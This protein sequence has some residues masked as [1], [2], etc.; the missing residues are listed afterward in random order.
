MGSSNDHQQYYIRWNNHQSNLSLV[1]DQLFRTKA[2]A[3][4]TLNCEGQSIKCHKLVI[5]SCSSYFADLFMENN[6]G[7]PVHIPPGIRYSEFKVLLEFMYKGEVTIP[8]RQLASVLM[9][10]DKLKVRG[11]FNID[12]QMQACKFDTSSFPIVQMQTPCHPQ[13]SLVSANSPQLVSTPRSPCI[14]SLPGSAQTPRS[15]HTKSSLSSGITLPQS[16]NIESPPYSVPTPT[17]QPSSPS[18]YLQSPSPSAP[19]PLP[20]TQPLGKAGPLYQYQYQL[21]LAPISAPYNP[22]LLQ[23]TSAQPQHPVKLEPGYQPQ[24]PL[25][26]IP[27]PNPPAQAPIAAGAGPADS[28]SNTSIPQPYS[29]PQSYFLHTTATSALPISF[30]FY[31]A[32]QQSSIDHSISNFNVSSNW[33]TDGPVDRNLNISVSL[34]LLGYSIKTVR[35]YFRCHN[36]IITQGPNLEYN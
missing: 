22:S 36:P 31:P 29:N 30:M 26:Y 25:V 3:D 14:Q 27:P 33:N 12:T 8:Q 18:Q 1:V 20:H 16:P 28:V 19:Y 35:Q 5:I 17:P 2:Y 21:H 11:L 4:V 23:F 10:A 15:R 24:V 9:A 32:G 7:D 6:H 13:S 34:L